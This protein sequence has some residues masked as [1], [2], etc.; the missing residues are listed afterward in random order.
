MVYRIHFGVYPDLEHPK[1]YNEKLNW[2]KLHDRQPQYTDIVDKYTVKKYISGII[3]EEYV[4]PTLGVW[5]RFEDIDFD[6][7][8][9]QFVLKCTHDSGG[10][11]ICRDKSKL[12]K[13]KARRKINS[14]LKRNYYWT[15]REWPYKNVKPRIIAEPYLED[16]RYGELRDYKFYVFDGVVDSVMVCKDR[17]KGRTKYYYF[18]RN[19]NRLYY[20]RDDL[21]FQDDIERP[22]HFDKMLDIAQRLSCDFSHIR[23]DLYSVNGTIYFS[24][25]T[26]YD[27]AGFGTDISEETNRMWGEKLDERRGSAVQEAAA[28]PGRQQQK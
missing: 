18:D 5:D 6:A 9:N 25:L 10:L 22:E 3:G 26:L 16:T 1:T 27:E 23:V 2:L 20:Q 19:W 11:V 17:Q 8:P 24:E 15:A 13:A 7:L 28:C 4:A 21:E 12:N 14:S